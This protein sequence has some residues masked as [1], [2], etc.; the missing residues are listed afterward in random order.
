MTSRIRCIANAA[1]QCGFTAIEVLMTLAIAAILVGIAAPSLIDLT[2]AQ[3]A[4]AASNDF[5]AGLSFARNEAIKRNAT[6]TVTPRTGG[7]VNGWDIVVNGQTLRS[8]A[9]ISSVSVTPLP[10]VALA[11]NQDG[12]LTSAGRY[13]LQIVSMDSHVP[14]RCVIVDPSG[15]PSVRVDN[16]R[17]GNCING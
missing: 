3:R 17:D 1:R 12:R 9:A 8:H 2:A 13:Q 10:A 5:Y 15:R 7:Y 6:V 16:N 4:K 14:M 11:Y